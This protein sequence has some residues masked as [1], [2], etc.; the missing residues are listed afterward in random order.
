MEE[1]TLIPIKPVVCLWYQFIWCNVVINLKSDSC[2]QLIYDQNEVNSLGSSLYYFV[3][4]SCHNW[5]KQTYTGYGK[6]PSI[7]KSHHLQ[8]R[9]GLSVSI[10]IYYSEQG[11]CAKV[12]QD[13]FFW[14]LN[15][16]FFI[17]LIFEMKTIFIYHKI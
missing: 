5:D 17:S 8:N 15:E 3:R 12:S 16:S 6:T 11:E 4:K 13:L 1:W 10:Y 2:N 7:Q 9:K 14:I